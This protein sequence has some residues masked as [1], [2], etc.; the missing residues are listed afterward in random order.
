MEIAALKAEIATYKVD[1]SKVQNTLQEIEEKIQIAVKKR[2][3]LYSNK[4]YAKKK[5]SEL[6]NNAIHH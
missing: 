1:P 5:I 3:K 4:T 6:Q 2:V